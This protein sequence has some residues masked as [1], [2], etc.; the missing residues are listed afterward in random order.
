MAQKANLATGTQ[1]TS[2]ASVVFD[3]NNTI[4]TDQVDDE[5]PSKGTDPSKRALV[6]IDAGTPTS[7]VTALPVTSPTTSFFVSWSG[8]DDAGGSGIGSYDIYVSD[9]GG[10]FTRWLAGTTATS[11][12]YVG[13]PGH[14]YSFFSVATDN[15]GNMEAL[16]DVAQASET[17]SPDA[18]VQNQLVFTQQPTDAVAGTTIGPAIVLNLEDDLGNPLSADNSSVTLAIFT[19]PDG[20]RLLGTAVEQAVN[21]V[22]TFSDLSLPKSG[23]YTLLA[24]DGNFTPATSDTFAIDAGAAAQLAIIQQPAF[25]YLGHPVSARVTV[26]R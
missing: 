16:A 13:A 8:T 24:S 19:G 11:A 12:A 3:D 23:T 20:G 5:D 18:I 25:D 26:G 10:P 6:T 7:S 4:T 22:A 14:T 2:V 21:G 15:V 17:V 9:N 1:I